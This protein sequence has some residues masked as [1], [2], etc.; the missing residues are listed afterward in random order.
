MKMK[1]ILFVALSLLLLLAF[2]CSDDT[3]NSSVTNPN[4]NTVYPKGYIQGTVRDACTQAP[5]VGAVVDIGIAKATTTST[6][7]YIMKNVPATS[8]IDRTEIDGE[9]E[10]G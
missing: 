4:P 6:G 9:L 10:F 8:Y 2:G 7:Q 1:K 3:N 5:I